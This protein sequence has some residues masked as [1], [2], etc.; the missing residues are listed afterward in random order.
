MYVFWFSRLVLIIYGEKIIS[1]IWQLAVDSWQVAVDSWQVTGG[2]WMLAGGSWQVVVSRWQV[3]GGRWKVVCG[4]AVWGL[5]IR[6]ILGVYT[7]HWDEVKTWRSRRGRSRSTLNILCTDM[8][9]SELFSNFEANHCWELYLLNQY[10]AEIFSLQMCSGR[11]ISFHN[12]L[13][14]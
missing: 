3:E 4:P 12:Q 10:T 8:D 1:G 14:T 9:V 7:G 11:S 13:T 2:R 5:W 6:L